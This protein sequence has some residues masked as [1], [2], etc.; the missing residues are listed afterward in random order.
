M[1]RLAVALQIG[2]IKMTGA[3]LNSVQLIPTTV[4]NLV[5]RQLG[6]GATPSNSRCCSRR[7]KCFS[8]RSTARMGKATGGVPPCMTQAG[9]YA[10]ALHYLKAAAALAVQA[11]VDA[12]PYSA[13]GNS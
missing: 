11:A 8:R 10:G 5:G 7:A 1:N 12:L 4:L 9:N 13:A 6:M 2:F 3:P